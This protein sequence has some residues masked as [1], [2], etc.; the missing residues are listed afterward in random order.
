MQLSEKEKLF[1]RFF[2]QFLNLDR[3]LKILKKKMT[4]IADVFL[5]LRTPQ[6]LIR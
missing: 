3:I 1:F 5:D 6:N 4:L 2:S